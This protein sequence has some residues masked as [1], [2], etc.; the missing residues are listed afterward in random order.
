MP[1]VSEI[2][3]SVVIVIGRPASICCQCR[4]DSSEI[5]SSWLSHSFSS[6]PVSSWFHWNGLKADV[7]SNSIRT[8]PSGIL[9]IKI[10]CLCFGNRPDFRTIGFQPPRARSTN[11]PLRHRRREIDRDAGMPC[12]QG[13]Y[14][15]K[16][17]GKSISICLREEL[18]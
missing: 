18:R 3:S 4:V 11:D 6:N 9:T 14:K 12:W 16:R 10:C 5:V 13:P 8:N 7:S 1:K 2:L 17:M 15:R